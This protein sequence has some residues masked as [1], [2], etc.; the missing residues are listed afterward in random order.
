M[1]R[2]MV[3]AVCLSL[4]GCTPTERLAY[5]VIVG[6]KAF[7]DSEKKAHTECSP[8]PVQLPN[9]QMGQSVQGTAVCVDLARATA[10]KDSLIDAVEIYCSGPQFATAGGA[11]Q[12]PKKGTPGYV[13][14][15]AKLKAAIANYSQIEADLKGLHQ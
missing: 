12:P 4:C 8:V 9:G 14:A 2:I 3:L 10:A 6:A 7:L 1:K 11:C 5:N 13:Q 15:E